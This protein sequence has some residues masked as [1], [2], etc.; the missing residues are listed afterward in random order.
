MEDANGRLSLLEGF[1]EAVG[2]KNKEPRIYVKFQ[3]GYFRQ[4]GTW[5]N[6]IMPRTNSGI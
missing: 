4:K 2:R 3:M 5:K 6:L 1:M